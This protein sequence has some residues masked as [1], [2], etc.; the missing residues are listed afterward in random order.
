MEKKK[1]TNMKKKKNS[2]WL[3]SLP[4]PLENVTGRSNPSFSV[5]HAL[6]VAGLAFPAG[7][8]MTCQYFKTCLFCSPWW[9]FRDSSLPRGSFV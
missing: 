5:V 4:S 1:N 8:C 6:E 7:E 9:I 3:S 2:D